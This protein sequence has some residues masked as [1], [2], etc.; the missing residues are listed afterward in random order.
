MPPSQCLRGSAR[1]PFPAISK[2]VSREWPRIAAP[3]GSTGFLASRKD[4]KVLQFGKPVHDPFDAIFHE[5]PSS[6]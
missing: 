6:R 5:G 3:D 1:G 2:G 4:A